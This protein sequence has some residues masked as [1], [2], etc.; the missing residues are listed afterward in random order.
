MY[1]SWALQTFSVEDDILPALRKQPGG[2][3]PPPKV[4]RG[5]TVDR[6]E[7][8]LPVREME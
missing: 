2:I 4:E 3:A 5:G 7:L 6:P 1:V 8:L